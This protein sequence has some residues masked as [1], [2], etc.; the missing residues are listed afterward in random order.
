MLVFRDGAQHAGVLLIDDLGSVAEEMALIQKVLA[1]QIEALA[2]GAFV[3]ANA[4]T[5]RTVDV[6]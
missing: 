1:S 6:L 2:G 5:V 3:R 4:L